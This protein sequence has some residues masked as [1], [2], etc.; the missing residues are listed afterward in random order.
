MQDAAPV[1]NQL[2]DVQPSQIVCDVGDGGY[3]ACL[4]PVTVAETTNLFL[5]SPILLHAEGLL[6]EEVAQAWANAVPWFVG[7][8]VCFACEELGLAFPCTNIG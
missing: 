8:C 7:V 5:C 4:P 6:Q 1:K 3:V 2:S